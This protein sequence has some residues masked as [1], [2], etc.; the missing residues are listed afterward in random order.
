A[1]LQ[2]YREENLVPLDYVDSK[3][4]LVVHF[5]GQIAGQQIRV[6]YSVPGGHPPAANQEIPET[7]GHA[8]SQPTAPNAK[9]ATPPGP[10]A[11]PE[12]CVQAAEHSRTLRPAFQEL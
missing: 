11:A 9:A 2:P 7:A 12:Q 5:A 3:L 8:T 4:A 6:C 10:A 1:A